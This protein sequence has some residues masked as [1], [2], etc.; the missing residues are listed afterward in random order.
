MSPISSARTG[1]RPA[2]LRGGVIVRTDRFA[3][4][5]FRHLGHQVLC[6]RASDGLAGHDDDV[7]SVSGQGRNLAPGRPQDPPGSVPLDR[8]AHTT[9]GDHGDPPEPGARN[10]TTRF[11]CNGRPTSN[12]RRTWDARTREVRR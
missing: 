3:A 9:G 6:L 10:S 11:A 7:V 2:G 12:T 5:Q 8:A 1:A 4:E